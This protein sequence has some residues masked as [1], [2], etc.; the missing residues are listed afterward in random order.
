MNSV[1][2]PVADKN[3]EI[4]SYAKEEVSLSELSSVE[5]SYVGGG[6]FNASFI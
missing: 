6:M 1:P 5:L 4:E 2:L 3:L